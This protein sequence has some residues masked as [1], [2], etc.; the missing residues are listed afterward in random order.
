VSDTSASLIHDHKFLGTSEYDKCH[1]AVLREGGIAR[2]NLGLAAHAEADI[3]PESE[4]GEGENLRSLEPE[5]GAPSPQGGGPRIDREPGSR[6]T[7]AEPDGPYR[8]PAHVKAI[9]ALAQDD[10]DT[11]PGRPPIM[12]ARFEGPERDEIL[13]RQG[14]KDD[15]GKLDWAALPWDA[16]EEVAEVMHFGA[17]KYERFNFRKGMGSLR[18]WSAALRHLR[19]WYRRDEVDPETG[20]SHLAHAV[21]CILMLRETEMIG[22][23][24]DDRP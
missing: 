13:A 11:D 20:K 21:C 17:Q 18:L 24:E 22:T 19:S 15:D 4:W 10:G 1:A 16:L 5:P 9:Q 7:A 6:G 14:H 2:C 3:K 23:S 12:R 8:V